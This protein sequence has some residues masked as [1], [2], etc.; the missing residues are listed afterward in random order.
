M[1]TMRARSA[2]F[3][4]IELLVCLAIIALLLAVVAPQYFSSV[5]NAEET[6]LRTNLALLRDA[7]DKHYADTGKYPGSL[8]ELVQKRY[9]RAVPVDPV[10]K[11]EKTWQ[12]LAPDDE[13]KGAVFGVRSGAEGVAR[14]GTRFAE[15]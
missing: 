8:E 2:A 3:T 6:V 4:L 14:D 5:T 11:S 9:I 15:W 7:L 10:T 1:V 12:V 13:R